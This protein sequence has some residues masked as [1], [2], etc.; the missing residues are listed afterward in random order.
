MRLYLVRHAHAGVRVSTDRHD[1]YRQLSDRGRQAAEQI[2]N[3]YG[4]INVEAIISS[5]ST[6]CVQTVEPLAAALK[7]DVVEDSRLWED[8]SIDE[9]IE[10]LMEHRD[11]GAVLCSHGNIIP[12]MLH[13]LI[14]DGLKT[15]GRGCA[16]GS[17]W[18]LVHKNDSFTRARYRS[19]DKL[20]H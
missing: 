4:G 11:S 7:L 15:K 13:W 17:V 8:A 12:E 19:L 9:A 2:A 10:V 1:K 6:R 5:P 3:S 14:Q 18:T 16:K 20:P